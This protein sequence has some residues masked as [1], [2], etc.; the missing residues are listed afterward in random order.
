MDK[1]LT[2]KIII[3]FFVIVFFVSIIYL[4]DILIP[5]FI[6]L[7]IAYLLDPFVDWLE[8]KKVKRALATS[9]VLLIFFFLIFSIFFLILPILIIQIKSFLTEFPLIVNELNNKL[10]LLFDY[11]HQKFL[12]MPS[13]DLMNNLAPSMSKVITSTLRNIISSSFAIF[14]LIALL[15]VTPIVSWY[16]LKDWD[17]IIKSAVSLFSTENKILLKEYSKGINNILDSYLRGQLIVGLCL[18]LYYFFSFYILDLNYSL[19]IGLFTGFF[20][21]IPFLGIIISFIITCILSY[22]QFIDLFYLLYVLIIFGVGQ[23]LESNFLTP[24]LIGKKLGLHPLIVL[25]SIFIFGSLFGIIGII[26]AIPITSIIIL[27]LKRNIT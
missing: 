9:F 16:F 1:L 25:L 5:F 11:I 23:L 6:G 3:S 18:S 14:N 24:N 7:F 17:K 26:F 8:K 22:L 21:F 12:L 19:F 4:I 15:I 20:S 2:K 27:I 13:K 10:M